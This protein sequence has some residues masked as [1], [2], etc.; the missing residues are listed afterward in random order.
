MPIPSKTTLPL[1]FQRGERHINLDFLFFLE[2][3]QLFLAY[4]NC[5]RFAASSS[6]PTP[7]TPLDDDEV[8]DLIS[9]E[10]DEMPALIRDV[11]WGWWIRAKL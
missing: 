10:D 6:Q 8:P 11:G 4:D 3:P 1:N 5:F 7:S 9:D 2:C